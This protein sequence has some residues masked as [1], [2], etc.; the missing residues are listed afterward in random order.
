MVAAADPLGIRLLS[1]PGVGPDHVE[2]I[3]RMDSLGL[4]RI[5]QPKVT[6]EEENEPPSS[7]LVIRRGWAFAFKL[8]TETASPPSN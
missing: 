8:T 4:P 3:A 5:V 1:V 6:L 2:A 7:L